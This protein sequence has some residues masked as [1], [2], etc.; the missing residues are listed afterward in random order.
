MKTLYLLLASCAVAASEED[1]CGCSSSRDYTAPQP[2]DTCAESCPAT[3]ATSSSIEIHLLPIPAQTAILGYAAPTSICSTCDWAGFVPHP[4][5]SETP[6]R[7]VILSSYYID[8]YPVSVADFTLFQTAT[9]HLPTAAHYN[10][11]FVFTPLAS[12]T[13]PCLDLQSRHAAVNWWAL[14]S[15]VSWDR[16]FGPP[17]QEGEDPVEG[18]LD[19]PVTHV[20][21]FDARAFC[22]WRGYADAGVALDKSGRKWVTRLPTE[23]EW[24]VASRGGKEGR[25]YP[26]GNKEVGGKGFRGNY[27]QVRKLRSDARANELDCRAGAARLEYRARE[28]Y[29]R[30]NSFASRAFCQSTRLPIPL[31]ELCALCSRMCAAGRLS[32]RQQRGGWVCRHESEGSVPCTERLWGGGHGGECLGVDGHEVEGRGRV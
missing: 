6:I 1:A 22:K 24:E 7:T 25:V 30:R 10:D 31:L 27:Y 19:H 5:D 20:S 9:N 21:Y 18:M 15:G 14:A 2:A 11:S 26:W 13:N 32:G 3:S 16:P 8:K 29:I 17:C 23:E 28:P 4:A 12:Q